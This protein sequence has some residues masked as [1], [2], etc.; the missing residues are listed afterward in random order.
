MTVGMSLRLLLQM[1]S[2]LLVSRYMGARE[3]G[4]FATVA[5]SV[6]IISA[7][8]GWGADQLI[9]RTVARAPSAFARAWGSG[10][11]FLGL[12]APPL[13]VASYLIVP[14]LV[15]AAISRELIIYVAIADIVFARVNNIAAACYQA[16]DQPIGT[17][18]LNLVF[19]G[20][21][22]AGALL[23]IALATRRDAQSWSV[24]YCGASGLYAAVSVW[25]V[26][27]D[28]GL[29]VWN[30]AYRDWRDGLHFSLQMASL[31]A[32]RN[33]DKPMVA[34][35]SNLSTAGIYAAA[36]RIVEAALVP[37]RALSFSTAARFFQL[38]A[39]G[40]NESLK[41]AVRMLPFGIAIGLIGSFGV[42]VIAPVAPSLLGAGYAGTGRIMGILAAL[43]VLYVFYYLAAD[44][45]RSSHYT[46]LRTLLQGVM[47]LVTIALCAVLVPPYGAAGGAIASLLSYSTMAAAAWV[48]AF[49]V[50]SRERRLAAPAREPPG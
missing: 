34:L 50:S 8:S 40:A 24:Y 32:F 10:L 1:G 45:L 42:V 47:P 19:S 13:V 44:V 14:L 15:D 18:R 20:A 29:P 33:I 38:G 39:E 17:A 4:A 16:V 21:R 35:L 37:A 36:S 12:S 48:L 7:F 5:A 6:A 11:V 26:C 46:G 9:L 43:P 49:V 30:I 28:L 25:Q 2:F 3:F 31:A 23:W 27:R 41:L 22:L